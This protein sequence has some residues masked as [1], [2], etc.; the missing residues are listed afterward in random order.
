[1]RAD[2]IEDDVVLLRPVELEQ[3]EVRLAPVD[4]VFA[5]GI[6]VNLTVGLAAPSVQMRTWPMESSAMQFSFIGRIMS[7]DWLTDSRAQRD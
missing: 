1:M 7:T 2:A 5:L 6:A 4:T 3:A